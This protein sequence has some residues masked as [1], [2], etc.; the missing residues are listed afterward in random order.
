MSS[1]LLFIWCYKWKLSLKVSCL[2][3][4]CCYRQV[5]G[6]VTQIN[7][8]IRFADSVVK[9]MLPR[10]G[11]VE[12]S[13]SAVAPVCQAGDQL[14]LTCTSSGTIH[15]WEVTVMMPQAM[16]FP[17]TPILSIGGTPQLVM[18][19]NS[20]FTASKLSGDGSLPLMSRIMVNPVSAVLNGTVVN[21]FEGSSSTESV[22]TTTIRIIDPG[23]FGM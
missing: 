9:L 20:T 17:L 14:E 4:V 8:I 22:A 10:T 21:C 13:P 16:N 2:L 7:L 12:I 23:Q 19:N 5:K 11:V 6:I 1:I 18:I 15:R 3:L